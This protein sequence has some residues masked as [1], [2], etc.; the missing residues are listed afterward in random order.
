MVIHLFLHRTVKSLPSPLLPSTRTS[1]GQPARQTGA[2]PPDG[3]A[4]PLLPPA[5][6]LHLLPLFH[7][8]PSPIRNT[9]PPLPTRTPFTS[10]LSSFDLHHPEAFSDNLWT[11]NLFFIHV[12][13]TKTQTA[14]PL[15]SSLSALAR[16]HLLNIRMYVASS[17]ADQ[18][19]KVIWNSFSCS[20]Q[21]CDPIN[22]PGL[23]GQ[24]MHHFSRNSHIQCASSSCQPSKWIFYAQVWILT[25]TSVALQMN[26]QKTSLCSKYC[27]CT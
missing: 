1:R 6:H 14:S 13:H 25:L 18:D 10:R 20:V 26:L 7:L 16:V 12:V 2:A 24:W 5:P 8:H 23:P 3:P 11:V 21:Q 4:A 19:R 27:M 15:V 22:Q 9:P 17:G